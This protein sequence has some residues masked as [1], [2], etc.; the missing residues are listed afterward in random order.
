NACWTAGKCP[1]APRRTRSSTWCAAC[2]PR[3]EQCRAALAPPRSRVNNSSSARAV[4]RQAAMSSQP[5][6]QPAPPTVADDAPPPRG[7]AHVQEVA[8]QH[9]QPPCP[10]GGA[11]ERHEVPG[12]ETLEELGRGGMG[13]V[14]KARQT[15]LNR[16]VALK[17]ILAGPHAGPEDLARFRIEA[18]AV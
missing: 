11:A 13:V 14:Y 15:G 8:T 12:Y 10:P 2:R 1:T 6:N 5:S 17:M 3:R 16:L 4:G 9:M 7:A 18:E